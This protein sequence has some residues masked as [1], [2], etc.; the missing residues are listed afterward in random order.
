MIVDA[1]LSYKKSG[2]GSF[3]LNSVVEHLQELILSLDKQPPPQSS[4]AS[5][6]NSFLEAVKQSVKG[7]IEI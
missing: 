4:K 5:L 7:G 6:S 1:L 3:E 2:E